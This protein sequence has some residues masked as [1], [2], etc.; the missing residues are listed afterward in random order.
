MIGIFVCD[1][2]SKFSWNSL[3]T[4]YFKAEVL[5]CAHKQPTLLETPA[6]GDLVGFLKNKK[7][8]QELAMSLPL[9]L[10]LF[11]PELSGTI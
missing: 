3:L 6:L 7:K 9:H 8:R 4:L 11:L 1:V 5:H 10:Q 2:N